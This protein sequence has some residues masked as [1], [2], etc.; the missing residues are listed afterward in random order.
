MLRGRVSNAGA[1][2]SYY[3]WNLPLQ[4]SFSDFISNP[5]IRDGSSSH[6]VRPS[7][8]D[9]E[10]FI[11]PFQGL[12]EFERQTHF[13]MP[14]STDEAEMNVVLSMLARESSDSAR[15]ESMAVAIG[16]NLGED[17][18]IQ[19]PECARHKRSRRMDHLAAPDEEKNTNTRLQRLSCLEQDAGPS[20]SLL[21]DGPASTTPE[22]DV[23][24]CDD[25]GLAV[26]A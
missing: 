6:R 24:G 23:R 21:G 8:D 11:A 22:D 2:L 1:P 14:T 18:E 13:E 3:A 4:S 26:C 25:A 19:K 5:P 10:A 15:T 12:P 20:T 9:I 16:Q 7:G 17:E